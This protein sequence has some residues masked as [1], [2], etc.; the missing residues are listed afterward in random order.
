MP[1]S[2]IEVVQDWAP[3][4]LGDDTPEF[5][6]PEQASRDI[7]MQILAAEDVDAVFDIAGTTPVNEI[8]GKAIQIDKARAMRSAYDAGATMYLLLDVVDLETGESLKVT[9]GA[10]NVMAQLYRITQVGRLPVKGR[11]CQTDRPTAAGY[12]PL[13]LKRLEKAA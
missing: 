7:V 11:I 10:R 5:V 2:D 9:C 1:G 8:L 3:F 13:W 6:D 12:Y 4:L